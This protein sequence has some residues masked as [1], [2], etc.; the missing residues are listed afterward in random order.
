[1]AIRF[2][3]HYVTD[4]VNKAR[5]F[6]SNG[7]LIDGSR[8]VTL[9]GRDYDRKLGLIFGADYVNSSDLM[10]DYFDQGHVRIPVGHP[11][12]P[13][14]AA[15]CQQNDADNSLRRARRHATLAG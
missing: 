4:G 1:M 14:A 11:L 6:Y 9:Y 13:A 12:Y 2:M 15:R 3:K 5:V 7:S 10:T 8:P